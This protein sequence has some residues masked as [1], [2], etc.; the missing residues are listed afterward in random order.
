[1]IKK[2]KPQNWQIGLYQNLKC[3]FTYRH[4][5]QKEAAKH[6]LGEVICISDKGLAL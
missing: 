6:R 2:K 3:L 1:M 4:H 5:K